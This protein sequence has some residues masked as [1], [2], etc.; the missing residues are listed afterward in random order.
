MYWKF[1]EL[2]LK[3]QIIRYLLS[4][5]NGVGYGLI[6]LALIKEG[7]SLWIIFTNLTLHIKSIEISIYAL[8]D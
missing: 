2:Y 7:L 1:K 4:L 8:I 3:D 5:L 6:Y